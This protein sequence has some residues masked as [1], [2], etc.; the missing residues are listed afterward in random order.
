ML[1]P[2]APARRTRNRCVR[3]HQL[4]VHR[5]AGVGADDPA[6]APALQAIAHAFAPRL[7]DHRLG[8]R[9]DG[10][11]QPAFAGLLVL[12]PDQDVAVVSRAPDAE[13]HAV[14]RLLV[15][16]HVLTAAG[17]A[18][19]D[20]GRP[21]VLVAPD[22]EQPAAVR[23]KIEVAI[24]ALDHLRQDLAGGEVADHQ[25][26]V[27]RALHVL[28]P[29]VEPVVRRMGGRTHL[30]VGVLLG[31]RVGVQQQFLVR[32]RLAPPAQMA[33]VLG[34]Q[35]IA[36]EVLERAVR[37]GDRGVVLLDP[38]L[39]LLEE[40]LLQILGPRQHRGHVGVLGRQVLAH[41]GL[42]LGRIAQHR[43]PVVVLH[44][45]VVVDADAPELLD[46]LG[47]L[48]RAGRNGRLGHGRFMRL[49]AATGKA[50][51]LS[52]LVVVQFGR[53]RVGGRRARL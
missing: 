40:L 52:G 15:D 36:A 48:A 44:P 50:H 29:G 41:V 53:Q 37:R 2:R 12:R 35:L 21:G 46:A 24:G 43:L 8:G 51:L 20:L 5:A 11:D 39:H 26:V 49:A 31:P 3:H 25:A 38:P 9:I 16:Q 4:E 45:G 22:P 14:V 1:D 34:A 13:E 23:R 18:A 30:I 10:R 47:R 33:R 6:P 32:R 19:E 7:G 27:F 42:H 28:G 17:R